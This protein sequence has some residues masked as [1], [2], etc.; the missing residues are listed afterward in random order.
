[1]L[2]VRSRSASRCRKAGSKNSQILS[3]S[4]RNDDAQVEAALAKA[5]ALFHTAWS[6]G[7]RARGWLHLHVLADMIAEIAIC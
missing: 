2:A 6:K 5:Q 4:V 1:M 3:F 7:E